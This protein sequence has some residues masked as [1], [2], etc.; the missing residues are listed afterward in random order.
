MMVVAELVIIYPRLK[1]V[2]HW[3]GKPE[4]FWNFMLDLEFLA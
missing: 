4:D 3:P 1:Y 2:S